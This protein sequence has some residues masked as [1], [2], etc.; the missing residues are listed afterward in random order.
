[1]IVTNQTLTL[2]EFLQ[3]PETQ[4][5]SEYQDGRV[6]PKAMP[7]SRHSRLQWML[8]QA[9]NQV[10][11]TPKIAAAFPELRCTIDDRSLVPDLAVFRWERIEFDQSGEP[12][13]DVKIAPDWT[14]EILSPNQNSN[15]VIN[16]I[17][18]CLQYDCQ[19]GWLVDPE[20]RSIIVFT[21]NQQ[22]QFFAGEVIVPVLPDISLS[23]TATEIFGWLKMN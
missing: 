1:M 9:I 13:D 10:V 12:V 23:L 19:L 11:A 7:K 5:A 18:C 20:D 22:P 17:L 3:L 8:L 6:Y 16:N 15:R 4:P 21:P 2:T 14:I